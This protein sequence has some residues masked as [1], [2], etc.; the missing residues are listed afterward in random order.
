MKLKQKLNSFFSKPSTFVFRRK[1]I[2][3]KPFEFIGQFMMDT[4][5]LKLTQFEKTG[6]KGKI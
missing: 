4:F 3:L 2:A 6:S 1:T 5:L